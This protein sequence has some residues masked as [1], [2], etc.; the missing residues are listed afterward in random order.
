MNEDERA[1]HILE[2]RRHEV[3]H[4]TVF[5]MHDDCALGCQYPLYLLLV[6]TFEQHLTVAMVKFLHLVIKT[7][8]LVKEIIEYLVEWRTRYLLLC[9]V[10]TD[11]NVTLLY[12]QRHD[13]LLTHIERGHI[14]RIKQPCETELSVN[15]LTGIKV[16][17]I[18]LLK[19]L[20]VEFAAVE[21]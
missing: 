20:Q 10:N 19:N 6:N 7:R 17:E 21:D 18:F 2:I 5:L 11:D 13:T 14:G 8:V 9:V 3:S 12:H 16:R 4:Q 1:Q 15:H